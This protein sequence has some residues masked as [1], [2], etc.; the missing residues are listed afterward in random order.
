MD[1]KTK[2]AYKM[3]HEN[4]EDILQNRQAISTLKTQVAGIHTHSNKSILD[5]TTASYLAS[6]K[7]KLSG[8]ET[9]ANKNVQANWQEAD[10]TKDSFIQNKPS[11]PSKTSELNN[12][13]GFIS[14][15]GQGY[16]SDIDLVSFENKTLYYTNIST[17]QPNGEQTWGT[18]QYIYGG[19]SDWVTQI[20]VPNTAHYFYKREYV[21]GAWGNWRQFYD[22]T[23]V[24]NLISPTWQSATVNTDNAQGYARYIKLGKFVYCFVNI[25]I[26][27]GATTNS[28][29]ISGLPK[30]NLNGLQWGAMQF[31]WRRTDST[32]SGGL[33]VGVQA[34]GNEGV[35]TTAYS[36]NS[37]FVGVYYDELFG[38][39]AE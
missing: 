17:N 2:K 21:N 28:V 24:D 29:L 10:T 33:K 4:L 3:S 5:Q 11:I 38:Y 25:A 35:I 36:N 31:I 12:D 30:P 23:Y 20:V 1:T 14:S 9:G 39:L 22:K 7:Q 18:V 37:N 26:K 16:L 15:G 8:I 19:N 13:S 27:S 6:E 34:S 32:I